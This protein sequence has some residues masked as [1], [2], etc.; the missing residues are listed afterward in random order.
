VS[1]Q[2]KA[3]EVEAI[4]R[5][6]KK[7]TSCGTYGKPNIW[8]QTIGGENPWPHMNYFHCAQCLTPGNIEMT[9]S[10]EVW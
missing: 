2:E 4:L 3:D 9:V 6:E 1:D 5:G 7:C 8:G 10:D